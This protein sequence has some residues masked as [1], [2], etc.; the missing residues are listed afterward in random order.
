[1]L[2]TRALITPGEPEQ[3]LRVIAE[4]PTGSNFWTPAVWSP[5]GQSARTSPAFPEF[6]R[7][8]GFA[9]LWDQYAPPDLCRKAE[10][11]DYLCK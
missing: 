10:N 6:A 8:I 3:G 4:C 5:R 7:K 11:G 1:M 2:R 9:A